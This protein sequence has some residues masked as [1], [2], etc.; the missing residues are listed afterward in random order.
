MSARENR[1]DDILGRDV[2]EALAVATGGAGSTPERKAAMWAA[3]ENRLRDSRTPF[4]TTRRDSGTWQQLAPDIA[5]KVLDRDAGMET[6]L[7]RLAPGACL[8]AHAHADDEMCY[9]LEGDAR[10]GDVEVGPGDYHLAR[11]G[12]MHGDVTSR[13]GC[14]LL[15]RYGGGT[16]S[17]AAAGA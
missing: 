11:A 13:D 5:I 3:I 1:R 8:P 10:L 7:L 15:I 6:F 4:V 9:V 16:P 17:Y 12:T 2:V 14:L